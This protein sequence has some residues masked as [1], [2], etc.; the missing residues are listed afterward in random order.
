MTQAIIAYGALVERSQDG[1]AFT[2]MLEA[3]GV[4]LPQ[5]EQDY[6]EV[7]HLQSPNG[8]REYIKGMKDAGELSIPANYT[9]A[10]YRQQLEDRDFNGAI[11]YRVTLPLAPGQST[12][13][14][15]EFQG[16]PNPGIDPSDDPGA[17]LTMTITIRTTGDVSFTPGA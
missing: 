10:A 6:Q 16:Y 8:Y 1:S 14:I 15:F 2:Q 17:P 7:T 13:D 12:G 4:A 11:F 3:K 9:T 5:V